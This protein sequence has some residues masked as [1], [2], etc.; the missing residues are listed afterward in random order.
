LGST[1]LT[2]SS[3]NGYTEPSELD[4]VVKCEVTVAFPENVEGGLGDNNGLRD[5]EDE[6]AV[7]EELVSP[8]VCWKR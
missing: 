4:T 2:Y 8:R 7:Y 3:D 1:T 6:Y 5:F